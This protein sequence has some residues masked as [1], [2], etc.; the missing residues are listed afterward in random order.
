MSFKTMETCSLLRT[1][2]SAETNEIECSC[3]SYIKDETR[4]RYSCDQFYEYP[5]TT[6]IYTEIHYYC[7]T[8]LIFLCIKW[9]RLMIK[10]LLYENDD[11]HWL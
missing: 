9:I 10:F 1:N 8:S 11:E 6:V 4:P 5:E 3:S 7:V 2:S